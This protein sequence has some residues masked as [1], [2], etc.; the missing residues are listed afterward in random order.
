MAFALR[1]IQFA[2]EDP[3]TQQIFAVVAAPTNALFT[4]SAQR[5]LELDPLDWDGPGM[6]AFGM[7][8]SGRH[9]EALQIVDR[10]SQMDQQ[11]SFS[12]WVRFF[13]LC[14][15]GRPEE[16]EQALGTVNGPT[17]KLL[18]MVARGGGEDAQAFA[19][20]HARNLRRSKK[21]SALDSV[22]LTIFNAPLFARLGLV[23]EAL[24]MLEHSLDAGMPVPYD[25]LL[26][27]P[28]FQ[29]LTALPRFKRVVA[30]FRSGAEG[31]QRL[32]AEAE[33]KGNLPSYL[34]PGLA[35]LRQLLERPTPEK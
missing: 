34:R 9:L 18:L 2:P 26:S 3:R 35:E 29:K 31:F 7:T 4:H 5:S 16:A 24:W 32:M 17:D 27:E 14:R 15:M 8:L 12:R 25:W 13:T 30:G 10:T 21:L 6:V 23:E 28:E 22:N 1:G 20:Q 33:A 11:H 19:R